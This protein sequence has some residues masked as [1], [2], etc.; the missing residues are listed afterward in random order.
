MQGKV[1]VTTISRKK[2]KTEVHRAGATPKVGK[3]FKINGK[4]QHDD[5]A[6]VSPD[7]AVP[8]EAPAAG[9]FIIPCRHYCWGRCKLGDSCKFLHS[10]LTTVSDDLFEHFIKLYC[11]SANDDDLE[12]LRKLSPLDKLAV[13]NAGEMY[14]VQNVRFCAACRIKR[15]RQIEAPLQGTS[16]Q[17]DRPYQADRK[18]RPRS[19]S[20][21][22]SYRSSR[23]LRKSNKLVPDPPGLVVQTGDR[24]E[25]GMG[26]TVPSPLLNQAAEVVESVS[27]NNS[28]AVDL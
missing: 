20:R 13:V 9:S 22:R 6:Q 25:D 19:R 5:E 12:H 10:L 27:R 2:Q 23:A 7:V 26:A 21:S 8:G 1:T 15:S 24:R 4:V 16:E 28:H 17:Q 18:L 3:P 11:P 14:K